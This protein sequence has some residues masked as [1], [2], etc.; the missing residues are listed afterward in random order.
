MTQSL[1]H[2]RFRPERYRR[3]L[4]AIVEAC[5]AAESLDDASLQRILRLHPKDGRGFFNRS[6]LV[7]GLRFLVAEGAA[8]GRFDRSA[9]AAAHEAD[10]HAERRGAG[11]GADAALPLPGS[12]HLLPQ[13]RPH[14]EELP[15]ERARSAPRRPSIASTPTRR[16]RRASRRC[17]AIGHPVDKVELIVLGGTWTFYPESY[18]TWFVTRCF[19]ALNDFGSEPWA[20]GG[21]DVFAFEAVA[22]SVDGRRTEG[23]TAY[24]RVVGE[25]LAAEPGGAAGG[26]RRLGHARGRA[27]PQRVRARSLRR[28]LARDASR[29]ARRS[30]GRRACAAS[31]RPRSRSATR[32]STTKCSPSTTAATRPR[33]RGGRCASCAAPASRCRRT[34]C[35]TST[36]PTSS[37]ICATTSASSAIPRTGPTSSSSIRPAWSRPP[38]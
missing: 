4:S 17:D 35:R 2:Q 20:R 37:A 10:A 27:A 12:L 5:A 3:E 14:A 6:E 28:P 19:D 23:G 36:A 1:L 11:D 33:R 24:N 26:R 30:R 25:L 15:L 31:A 38:S 18:Q 21:A 16:R 9:A 29:P 8:P 32:A 7:L 13:R 22:A 34:G